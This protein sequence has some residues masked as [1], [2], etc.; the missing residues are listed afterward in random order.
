MHP[1]QPNSPYP[2]Q[3]AYQPRPQQGGWQ[4]TPGTPTGGYPQPPRQPTPPL[5]PAAKRRPK[6]PWIVLAIVVLFVIIIASGSKGN[7]S[8]TSGAQ[9]LAPAASGGSAT[10]PAASAPTTY[11]GKG[12]DVVTIKKDTGVAIVTFECAKCSGNTVLQSDGGDS[13]LVNTIGAYSGRHI[14]DATDGS[15]TSTLTVKAT[16]SWKITVASGLSSAKKGE[17]NASGR[18]DD[19]VVLTGKITKAAITNKGGG[20]NFV[21][22]VYGESGFPDLVVPVVSSSGV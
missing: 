10:A 19:V 3:R 13:L 6:W 17:T 7:T 9:P 21:V 20:S 1:Q 8:P 4:P 18:G 14:I 2:P 16:G 15:V 12:D 5:L 22:Q 11:T